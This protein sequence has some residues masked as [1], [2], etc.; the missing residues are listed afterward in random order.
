[1]SCV[2]KHYGLSSFEYDM[3]ELVNSDFWLVCYLAQSN[4]FQP[5]LIMENWTRFYNSIQQLIYNRAI[6]CDRLIKT[7][8]PLHTAGKKH[9]Y[10]SLNTSPCYPMCSCRGVFCALFSG[11]KYSAENMPNRGIFLTHFNVFSAQML[12][13]LKKKKQRLLYVMCKNGHKNVHK[14]A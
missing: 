8:G 4:V 6:F 14:R 5:P 7:L 1:M 10:Q 3:V 9:M 2:I 13:M 12:S 11:R